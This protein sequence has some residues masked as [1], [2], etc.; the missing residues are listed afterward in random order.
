MTQS[1]YIAQE[2]REFI[3]DKIDSVPQLEALLLLYRHA[4]EVWTEE[5]LRQ[6]LYIDRADA[7]RI[8]FELLRR[9]WVKAAPDNAGIQFDGTWDPQLAIMGK[10]D[11]AYRT[12]LIGISTLIHSKGSAAARDFANAFDLKKE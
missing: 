6:A 9:G 7:K 2:V 1:D 10:L 3:L 4:D 12:R 8:T 5:K 11:Q